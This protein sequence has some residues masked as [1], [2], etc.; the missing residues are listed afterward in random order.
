M[1]TT[2]GK[3]V[4][5]GL[6]EIP[7]PV[8]Y[9]FNHLGQTER[10]DGTTYTH[11]FREAAGLLWHYV[12]AGDPEHVPIIF[13]HGVPDSW[14]LWVH[15]IPRLASQYY[16]IALDQKGFGQSDKRECSYRSPVV[17]EELYGFINALLGEKKFYLVSHD[18][19]TMIADPLIGRRHAQVIKWVRMEAPILDADIRLVPQFP[20]YAD[21]TRGIAEISDSQFV[22]LVY[23]LKTV[24]PIPDA[25]LARVVAEFAF[26]GTGAAVARYYRDNPFHLEFAQPGLEARKARFAACS[27]PV[28]LL[29]AEKDTAQPLSLFNKTNI[30]AFPDAV[31]HVVPDSGHFTPHERPEIVAREIA[32]FFSK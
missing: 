8:T 14:F 7:R 18:W 13:L 17:A 4:P 23:K 20:A 21:Y 3:S 32:E 19:G 29:Q 16:C 27:F 12:T 15:V 1:S 10:I 30:E 2:T 22:R 25:D 24:R 11:H 6:T 5:T 31:L 9:T 28:L 26:P